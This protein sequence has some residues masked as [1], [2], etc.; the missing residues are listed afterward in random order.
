MQLAKTGLRLS[1]LDK[2]Q[3]CASPAKFA[4]I[5]HM[6]PIN[7]YENDDRDELLY[8]YDNSKCDAE[9]KKGLQFSTSNK[10]AKNELI[11]S[12]P[13]FDRKYIEKF[14]ELVLFSYKTIRT[15]I[16]NERKKWCNLVKHREK[17][18]NMEKI[19]TEDFIQFCIA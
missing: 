5:D 16:N 17:T 1:N 11:Q 9:N 3:L 8:E 12:S 15:K 6:Q 19:K 18:M 4:K 14:Q 7:N 10:N 13:N 2:G